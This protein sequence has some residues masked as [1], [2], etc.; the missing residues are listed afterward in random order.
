MTTPTAR[1][2]AV[3]NHNSRE[4]RINADLNNDES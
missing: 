1:M 4:D 3:T 2:A